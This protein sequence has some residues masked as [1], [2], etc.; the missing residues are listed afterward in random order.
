MYSSEHEKVVIMFLQCSV[1]TRT[2][3]GG[4]TTKVFLSQISRSLSTKNCENWL[5]VDK[6]IAV[7]KRV[8][9]LF[10]H[11]VESPFYKNNN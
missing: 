6:V 2:P 10:D 7:I 3:L 9:F 4:L 11:G 1:V 8:T 5:T